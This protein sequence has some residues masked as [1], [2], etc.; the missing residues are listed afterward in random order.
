MKIKSWNAEERPREKLMQRGAEALDNTELLAI[1]LRSGTS[2]ESAVDLSRRLLVEAGNSLQNL[3]RFS[4]DRIASLHGFGTVKAVTVLAALELARRLA[5]TREPRPPQLLSSAAVA[6]LMRPL[7]R[8]LQH[9]ECWVL[10]V[11]RAN[12]LI[13]KERMSTGG[14][15]ATVVDTK[16]IVRKALE[17]SASGIILV[18]NHPSG[19]PRPGAQDCR[20]TALLRDAVRYFDISLLDHVIIAGDRYYSF[21]DE[22]G[23]G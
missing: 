17:K 21:N 22:Q 23:I 6:E 2:R 5:E 9:E 1:L 4:Y 13:G 11:N 8:H 15:T 18:H 14:L 16:I 12:R 3:A 20:Q 10:Y 7:L 19:E